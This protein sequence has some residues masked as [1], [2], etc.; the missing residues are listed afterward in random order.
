MNG[1]PD[2]TALQLWP[3]SQALGGT[4][5]QLAASTPMCG[6][7]RPTRVLRCPENRMGVRRTFDGDSDGFTL[8][9]LGSGTPPVLHRVAM[10][11][12]AL[13]MARSGTG[14]PSRYVSSTH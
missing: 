2:F 5:R 4:R 10:P 12:E 9:I 6:T 13:G 14:C 7:A 3:A 8:V 11:P 1:H